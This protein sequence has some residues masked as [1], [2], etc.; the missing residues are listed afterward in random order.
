MRSA[1]RVSLCVKWATEKR[2]SAPGLE[3]D[4]ESIVRDRGLPSSARGGRLSRYRCDIRWRALRRVGTVFA[5]HYG[6][7]DMNVNINVP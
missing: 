6:S 4:R 2:L 5:R 1:I 3:A 7:P